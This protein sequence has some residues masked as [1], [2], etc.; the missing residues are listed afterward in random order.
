M[1]ESQIIYLPS[2]EQQMDWPASINAEEHSC[3]VL[4]CT[5]G[6]FLQKLFRTLR[7]K[8]CLKLLNGIHESCHSLVLGSMAVLQLHIA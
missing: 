5:V 1:D 3:A 4:P 8:S 7:Y 2:L 6:F